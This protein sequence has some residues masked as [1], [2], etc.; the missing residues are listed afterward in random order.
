AVEK[1]LQQ[2]QG[3]EVLGASE[4]VEGR[5]ARQHFTHHRRQKE[6]D[7]AGQEA[8]PPRQSRQGR[9]GFPRGGGGDDG[10]PSSF[11]RV[12]PRPLLFNSVNVVNGR[13]A[14]QHVKLERDGV[15]RVA[16]RLLDEWGLDGLSLR[17]LAAELGVKAPALYWYFESKQE[18]LD[19]MADAMLEE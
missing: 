3:Q 10:P 17:R 16:L 11:K 13:F 1:R 7:A 9:P 5:A 6:E 4:D 19:E 18:L 2:E 8:A 14:S 15:V 12:Q